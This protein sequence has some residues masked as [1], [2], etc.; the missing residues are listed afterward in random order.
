MKTTVTLRRPI[1]MA[2]HHRQPSSK[3][4][5]A[6]G[7]AACVTAHAAPSFAARSWL[8]AVVCGEVNGKRGC[9]E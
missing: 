7:H 6:H 5:K 8:A 2:I 9:E 3:H 4:P 1:P